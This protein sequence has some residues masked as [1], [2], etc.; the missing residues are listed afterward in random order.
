M[1]IIR[2]VGEMQAFSDEAR[3]RGKRIGFTPTMGYLHEGHLSLVRASKADNDLT[4]A[5]IYVNPT[6]FGPTEDL[7]K[8]PRDLAR[9]QEL[10]EHAGCE[11][12][13]YPDNESMYPPG[14]QTELRVKSITDHLCGA[15]RPWHFPGVALIVAKLFNMVKPH[16]AY[17]G[18]KDYQ[19]ARVIRRM[20]IDLNFD[21]EVVVCPIVRE[22]DGLAM[23][24]RNAYLSDEER[25][26]AIVLS[27]ALEEANEMY[28]EGERDALKLK[29]RISLTIQRAPLAKIDYCEVVD[30]ETIQP[31]ERVE[32]TGVAALAVFFGKTRLI[33]NHIL[34][35][36]W[37]LSP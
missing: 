16:R 28:R 11:A 23:S 4:V 2:T 24:S 22:T 27:Q 32:G 8:Y 3:A 25:E 34:G 20:V 17:F 9:D 26:Q 33:D 36:P 15:S 13:F 14:F 7:E 1:K 6:Q 10:L 29:N 5:S 35:E 21:L 12:L 37:N 18:Q 31:I 19:Q 30:G